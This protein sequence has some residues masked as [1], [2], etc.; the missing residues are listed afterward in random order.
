MSS[1][2]KTLDIPAL[3]AAKS[4]SL[5][6]PIGNTW[7][8]KVTS[9]VIAIFLFTGMPVIDETIEVTIPIPAEGP[10]FGV[11]PSGTWTWKSFFSKIGGIIPNSK[12]FDLT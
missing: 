9:P 8:L 10:S 11:A 4:F 2:I 6:P 7:P 12:D 3:C 1:G 5:S